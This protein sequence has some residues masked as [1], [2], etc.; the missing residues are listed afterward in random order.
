MA[1]QEMNVQVVVVARSNLKV[2]AARVAVTQ[3]I[4][5]MQHTVK[6]PIAVGTAAHKG[7]LT[8]IATTTVNRQL[9]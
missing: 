4:A 5:K 2:I 3:S 9:H 6:N 1:H 8:L 7:L